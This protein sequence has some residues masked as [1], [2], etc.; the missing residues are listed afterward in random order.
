[1]KGRIR[2]WLQE[3]GA[4]VIFFVFCA[5]LLIVFCAL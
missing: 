1:M 4:A 2:G 5:I 3:A